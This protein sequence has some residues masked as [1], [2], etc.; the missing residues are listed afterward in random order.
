MFKVR[1]EYKDLLAVHKVLQ[2]FKER[3]A[4]QAHKVLLELRVLQA[5][6]VLLALKVPRDHKVPQ[7]LKAPLVLKAH[8]V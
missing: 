7:A 6:R 4:L 1:L 8:R 2:V 5:H 3:Q